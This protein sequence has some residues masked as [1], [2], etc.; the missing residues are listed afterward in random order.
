MSFPAL[1][2][3]EMN[4]SAVATGKINN[5]YTILYRFVIGDEEDL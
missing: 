4:T 5:L 3:Q 2:G 1:I